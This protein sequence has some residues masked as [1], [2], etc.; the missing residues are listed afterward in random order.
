MSAQHRFSPPVTCGDSPLIRGG[1]LTSPPCGGAKGCADFSPRKL[2]SPFGGGGSPQARRRGQYMSAERPLS[3]AA[4]DSS[5]ARGEP[6]RGRSPRR[7]GASGGHRDPPLQAHQQKPPPSSRTGAVETFIW[8]YSSTTV[9]TP[10][11][12]GHRPLASTSLW[13]FQQRSH[14]LPSAAATDT[15]ISA[16][17]VIST[18]DT[19]N[20]SA[21]S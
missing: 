13:N 17:T 2:A 18:L 14:F 6:S 8:N 7:P 21:T 15:A 11:Q 16:P 3:L 12:R 5:P 1:L 20:R 4:L 19:M 10:A 9:T